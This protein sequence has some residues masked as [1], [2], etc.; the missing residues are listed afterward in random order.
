MKTKSWWW[1]YAWRNSYLIPL[2]T[3]MQSAYMSNFYLDGFHQHISCY[4][5]NWPLSKEYST[6]PLTSWSYLCCPSL[7]SWCFWSHEIVSSTSSTML[8]P[9]MVIQSSSTTIIIISGV[10][11]MKNHTFFYQF[12]TLYIYTSIFAFTMHYLLI[13]LL[14]HMHFNYLNLHL[15]LSYAII[16]CT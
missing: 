6:L 9:S 14:V 5:I 13:C 3:L 1:K 2:S 7:S 16:S 4:L 15:W 11:H 8:Q 12:V 10:E